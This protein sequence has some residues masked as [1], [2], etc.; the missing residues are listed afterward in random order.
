MLFLKERKLEISPGLKVQA[1][2]FSGDIWFMVTGFLTLTVD[3]WLSF[4]GLRMSQMN[5]VGLRRV[6]PGI[7]EMSTAII[8]PNSFVYCPH[9]CLLPKREEPAAH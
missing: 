3:Q 2:F 7:I 8:E 6:C 9:S 5:R 1:F 4:V